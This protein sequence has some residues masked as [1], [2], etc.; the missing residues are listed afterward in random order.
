VAADGSLATPPIA[1]VEVQGYDYDAKM[2]IASLFR[3]DGD[4]ERARKLEEEAKA[5]RR[6]FNKDYWLEKEK[7][8]TLALQG[9]D[10]DI[11]PVITSNPGHALWSGIVDK[12]KTRPCVRRL[13]ADDMY[14]GWGVRTL[15]CEDGRYNPLGYHLGSV[16]PHDNAIILAGFRRYGFDKEA[17]QIFS[18][19]VNAST[20]FRDYRLPELYAGYARENYDE[21]VSYPVACHP[22]AWAASSVP[23]MLHELLGLEADAFEMKLRITR[24]VLPEFV[25]RLVMRGLRVGDARTDL[26]F[27]RAEGD[28]VA[29]EVLSTS[30]ELEIAIV[31]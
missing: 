23:F 11:C 22:Q 7:F 10:K 1:L 30:G 14:S 28:A 13:M 29:V 31:K 2:S 6:R 21:P 19:I 18:D 9:P 16:W 27:T 25:D 26:K 5:L 24:P 12:G 15:S 8:F 4:E 3:R 17:L 20:H